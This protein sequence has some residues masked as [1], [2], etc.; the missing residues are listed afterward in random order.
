[1]NQMHQINA[2]HQGSWFHKGGELYLLYDS[3]QGDEQSQNI[4]F[5]QVNEFH[6]NSEFI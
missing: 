1:M 2:F 3:H 4:I 5:Q 6:R